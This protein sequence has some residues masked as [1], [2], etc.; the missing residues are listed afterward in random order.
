MMNLMRNAMAQERAFEMFMREAGYERKTTF[1][2]DFSVADYF[3]ERAVK[4]TFKK[5][6]DGYKQDV[7]YLTE[8]VMVLNHKIGQHY[9]RNNKLARLY[10]ELWREADRY[11]VE[12]LTG[13]DLDYFYCTTD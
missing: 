5:A 2:Y 3:G 4:D 11:C 7:E 1:F 6:F 13:A 9:E 8:L 10:D 12:N